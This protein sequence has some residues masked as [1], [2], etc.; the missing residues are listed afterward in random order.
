MNTTTTVIDSRLLVKASA[1]DNFNG[2]GLS[3]LLLE[4]T[5]GAVV[6]GEINNGSG[7]LH[8]AA[9]LVLEWSFQRNGDFLGNGQLNS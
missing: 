8:E 6:V 2:D 5:S 1:T 4:N 3:D 7:E 9:A